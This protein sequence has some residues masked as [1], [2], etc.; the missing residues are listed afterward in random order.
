[1]SDDNKVKEVWKMEV[2]RSWPKGR[3]CKRWMENLRDNLEKSG[4]RGED[5]WDRT[6]WRKKIQMP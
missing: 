2:G 3:P 4:L 5:A 1:M 6:S